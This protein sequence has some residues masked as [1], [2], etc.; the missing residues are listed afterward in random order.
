MRG[1]SI[2]TGSLGVLL[3]LLFTPGCSRSKPNSGPVGRISGSRS[4]PPVAFVAQWGPSNRYI[5]HSEVS[6]SS[7]E[8]RPGVSKPVPQ[9][10]T[11]GLDYSITVSNTRSNG[12]RSLQLEIMAVQFDSTLG[13]TTLISYD[14]GNRVVGTDGNQLAERLQQIV[15]NKIYFQLSPSNRVLN[16]RGI[17]EITARI[18]SGGSARGQA[19]LRRLLS[20]Q[21]LRHLIDVTVLPAEPVRIDDTWPGELSFNLGSLGGSVDA[22][23]TYKF[24]GWQQRNN[25]KCALVEFEGNMKPRGT[26]AP[27]PKGG[28]AGAVQN[29]SLNGRTWFDPD[30]GLVVESTFDHT[31]VTTGTIK[32][33]RSTNSTPQ[34][35][36]SNLRHHSTIKLL[37]MEAIKPSE[38]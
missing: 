4:D 34:T 35:Y 37:D 5:F 17:N 16:V 26:N 15:G 25:H 29:G 12:A 22:D 31:A 7:D 10:S 18:N 14:S 13:D 3:A 23:V 19:A 32:W 38:G 9:E 20:P 24:R 2:A 27:P 36:T 6:A 28:V 8:P 21:Y 30:L 33:R 11:L 1:F